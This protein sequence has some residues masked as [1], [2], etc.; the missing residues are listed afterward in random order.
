[1]ELVKAVSEVTGLTKKDVTSVI[2]V[3]PNVVKNAVTTGDKVS[4]T[5]FITFEKVDIPEKTGIVQLC[6]KEGKAWSKPAHSEVKVKL[7]KTYKQL[8]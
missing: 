7:S 1:M 5:G 3:L 4:L 6:D 8:Q 2:D